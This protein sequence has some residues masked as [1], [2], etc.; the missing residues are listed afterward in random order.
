M[1][2]NDAQ[3]DIVSGYYDDYKQTQEEIFRLD[4]IK[5]RNAIFWI[6]GLLFASD[7]LGL[8]MANLIVAENILYALLF[9]AIFIAFGFL[10]LKQPMISI[11]LSIVLF[12]IIIFITIKAFGSRAAINGILIKAII[13]YLLISGFQSAKSAEQAKK[14][15]Q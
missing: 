14:E 4:A 5:V 15:S 11:V 8:A 12:G 1:D 3:Q 13:V 9:P 10:A 7:L 2:T 6:G